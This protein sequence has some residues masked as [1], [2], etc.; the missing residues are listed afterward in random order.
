MAVAGGWE[1]AGRQAR[2]ESILGFIQWP[3]DPLTPKEIPSG[4]WGKLRQEDLPEPGLSAVSPALP[5]R[6]YPSISRLHAQFGLSN[7]VQG[8]RRDHKREK[9]GALWLNNWRRR[10]FCFLND[11]REHSRVVGI[12]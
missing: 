3:V 10:F 9:G 8:L 6:K 2:A 5:S 4:A 11:Q 12:E 1:T 7:I